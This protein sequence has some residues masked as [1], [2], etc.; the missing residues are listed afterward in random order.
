MRCKNMNLTTTYKQVENTEKQGI[1]LYFDGIP[2]KE[3]RETL[4]ANGYRWHATKKCW[5]I[6]NNAKTSKQN[7]LE[8]SA[9]HLIT[10]FE[11]FK[12]V[13]S[14]FNKWITK[15]KDFEYFF[16]K[17]LLIQTKD[18]YILELDEL[19]HP[20]IENCMYYDDETPAPSTEFASFKHYNMQYKIW[21]HIEKYF[22][23][24]NN[25]KTNGCASGFYDYKGFWIACYD[26]ETRR[27]N[28]EMYDRQCQHTNRENYF[29]RYLTEEEQTDLLKVYEFYKQKY[30]DRLEKYYKRYGQHIHTWGY[31]ANR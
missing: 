31:W 17:Y 23:E 16:K 27:S 30:I 15:E 3:D 28:W 9:F 19:K 14:T 18:G 24:L 5:Y 29:A 10:D 22:D 7:T 2:S 25:L 4:K 11:E 21:Q 13:F 6:S 1:E 20:E 26:N 8:I 12:K